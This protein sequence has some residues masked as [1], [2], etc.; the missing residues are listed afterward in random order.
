M[1]AAMA[2]VSSILICAFNS[3]TTTLRTTIELEQLKNV[4]SNVAA[5]GNELLTVVTEADLTLKTVIQPPSK[6]GNKEYWMRLTN[7]SAHAWLEGA[8]G[9]INANTVMYKVFLPGKISVSGHYVS[10]Y[11]ALIMECYMN[12]TTRQLNIES[13]SPN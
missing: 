7:D 9:E 6:I 8:L 11:G 1:F 12:S 2:L 13:F 4:L 3:Y 10:S 5:K